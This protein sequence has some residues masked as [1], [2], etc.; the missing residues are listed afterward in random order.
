MRTARFFVF[1]AVLVVMLVAGCKSYS[2]QPRLHAIPNQ[3]PVGMVV[4]KIAKDGSETV[5][6]IPPG[7]QLKLEAGEKMR[8]IQFVRPGQESA[9]LQQQAAPQQPAPVIVQ[10]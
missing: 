8:I 10:Q 7:Q 4:A 6:Y 5:M 1:L 9:F 2:Q 3:Q